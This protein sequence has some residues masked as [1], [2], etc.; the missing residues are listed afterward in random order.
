MLSETNL[1]YLF[2]ILLKHCGF[3]FATAQLALACLGVNRRKIESRLPPFYAVAA[4]GILLWALLQSSASLLPA[5]GTLRL[6]LTAVDR[7]LR[8][9][10]L[11]L[12]WLL[13]YFLPPGFSLLSFS[14]RKKEK[15]R[16]NTAAGAEEGQTPDAEASEA[17]GGPL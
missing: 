10:L 1:F 13:L 2:F 15:R 8:M 9:L 16:P 5:E 6:A 7:L 12:W 11:P 14:R 4:G 17:N 3:Y